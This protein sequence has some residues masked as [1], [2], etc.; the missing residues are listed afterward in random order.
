[1]LIK[2]FCIACILHGLPFLQG[3]FNLI[4]FDRNWFLIDTDFCKAGVIHGLSLNF[5]LFKCQELKLFKES[6]I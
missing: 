6:F 5:N 4:K 1:M 3:S 2:D